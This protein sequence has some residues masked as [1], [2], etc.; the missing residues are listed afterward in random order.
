MSVEEIHQAAAL[1]RALGFEEVAQEY[2]AMLPR[3]RLA[4]R[5]RGWV[6]AWFRRDA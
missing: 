5:L 4:D 6:R 2:E 3:P 1:N